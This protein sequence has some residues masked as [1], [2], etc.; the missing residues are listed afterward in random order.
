MHDTQLALII[1]KTVVFRMHMRG[2]HGKSIPGIYMGGAMFIV[3][4]GAV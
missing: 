1:K 4:M 3:R 2:L